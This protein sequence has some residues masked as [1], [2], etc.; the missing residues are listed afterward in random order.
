[1]DSVEYKLVKVDK[2]HLRLTRSVE[3]RLKLFLCSTTP[4][5]EAPLLDSNKIDK[6]VGQY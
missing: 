5:S 4:Y 2:K 1:M 3:I 6:I